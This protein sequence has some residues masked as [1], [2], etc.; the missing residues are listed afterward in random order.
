MRQWIAHQMELLLGFSDAGL[1]SA[2]E[3]QKSEAELRKYCAELLGEQKSFI[4]ELVKRKFGSLNPQNGQQARNAPSGNSRGGKKNKKN[5]RNNILLQETSL[6]GQ[7]GRNSPSQNRQQAPVAAPKEPQVQSA[8][9][10]ASSL[11]GTTFS[12]APPVVD[13]RTSQGKTRRKGRPKNPEPEPE[14]EPTTESKKAAENLPKEDESFQMPEVYKPRS[15]VKKDKRKKFK[16]LDEADE[17]G[18]LMPGNF[19]KIEF[20][21][22][23][24]YDS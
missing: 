15:R 9:Q 16:T 17:G 24:I 8:A 19:K 18:F 7:N 21:K 20:I 23:I 13:K 10:L 14:P 4:D 3:N 12:N 2:I 5:S 1:I 11:F 22:T 6:P